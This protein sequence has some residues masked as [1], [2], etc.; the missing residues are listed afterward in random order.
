MLVFAVVAFLSNP[1]IWL[2]K[3]VSWKEEE[4]LVVAGTPVTDCS[5]LKLRKLKIQQILQKNNF[6]RIAFNSFS[7]TVAF[8]IE[9]SHLTY[10]ANQKIGFHRKCNI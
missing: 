3:N 8:D 7:S 1:E 5:F 10:T 2:H 6:R 9:T 4:I